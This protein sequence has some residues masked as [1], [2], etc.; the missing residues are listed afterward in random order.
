M[1]VKNIIR[2]EICFK[3][4]KRLFTAVIKTSRGYVSQ[5]ILVFET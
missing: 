5:F 1:I 3:S 4:L 2:T